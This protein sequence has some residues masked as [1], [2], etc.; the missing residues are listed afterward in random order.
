MEQEENI[1]K[2]RVI[3]MFPYQ[4]VDLTPFRRKPE[5]DEEKLQ[6]ELDRAMY[7]YITWE[8]G[9]QAEPG[10]VVECAWSRTTSGTGATGPRSR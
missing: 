6:K 5:I 4:K 2:S 8:D 10:D 9:G 1:L 7:P 3:T